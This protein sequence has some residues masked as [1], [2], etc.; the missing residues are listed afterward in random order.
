MSDEHTEIEDS[1]K[2]RSFDEGAESGAHQLKKPGLGEA[3]ANARILLRRTI[4]FMPFLWIGAVFL[5]FLSVSI[6]IYYG[7]S[8]APSEHELWGSMLFPTSFFWGISSDVWWG[9]GL[10]VLALPLGKVHLI[11]DSK[12]ECDS[13]QT[14]HLKSVGR[15]AIYGLGLALFYI[16]AIGATSILFVVPGLV[17]A[18]LL[19]PL[20]HVVMISDEYSLREI[21]EAPRQALSHWRLN[22]VAAIGILGTSYGLPIA[23]TLIIGLG[24]PGGHLSAVAWDGMLTAIVAAGVVAVLVVQYLLFVLGVGAA[25]AMEEYERLS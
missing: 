19:L 8:L 16:A 11:K 1:R 13:S 12:N 10:S 22:S 17:V 25:L 9:L 15:Q 2:G 4:K 7:A 20:F 23:A 6:P 3:V 5:A 18:F 21:R 24:A 14:K